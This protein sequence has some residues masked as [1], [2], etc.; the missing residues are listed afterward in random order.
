MS[1]VATLFAA[2]LFGP[3][4][5]GLVGAASISAIA[6]SSTDP[7]TPFA[8]PKVADLHEHPVHL[9]R[10]D[11]THRPG[12]PRPSALHGRIVLG[13]VRGVG[14]WRGVGVGFAALT[15]WVRRSR[16]NVILTV[17]VRRWRLRCVLST[18]RSSPASSFAY[19]KVSPGTAPPLPRPALAAQRLFTLYQA[20][21]ASRDELSDGQRNTSRD[22]NLSFAIALVTRSKR[23]TG[24]QQ[25][26]PEPS[27]CTDATSPPVGSAAEEQERAFCA[28]LVH[29]IGK[30]GLPPCV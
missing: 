26:I 6:S 3:L 11:G 2:V 14:S 9:G 17:G 25:V 23:V 21:A 18:R 13:D 28:G 15:A 20:K 19:V 7:T 30:I 27:L 10:S 22:A 12:D 8:T 5:G 4:A 29:D 1:P 24:I 16:T